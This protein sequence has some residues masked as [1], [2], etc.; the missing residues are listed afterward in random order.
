[1]SHVPGNYTKGVAFWYTTLLPAGNHDYYFEFNNGT[2]RH[3][4]YY[5]GGG[6]NT[7]NYTLW[8]T[9]YFQ[10]PLV[11]PHHVI[12]YQGKVSPSTGYPFTTYNYTVTYYN[13]NGTAPTSAVVYINGQGYNM[14]HV[15][16][17]YANGV[18]FWYAT[19]VSG[20]NNKYYFEFKEGPR[21]DVFPENGGPGNSLSGPSVTMDILSLSKGKVTPTSGYLYTTFNYTVIYWGG[22]PINSGNGNDDDKDGSVD[23]E[24]FNGYDDDGDGFIDEDCSN[25]HSKGTGLA[26]S[27]AY[28]YFDGKAH[29][30][31]HVPGNYSRGITFW[32]STKL[33][34]GNHQYYFYFELG[35]KSKKIPEVWQGNQTN[36]TGPYVAP[37]YTSL[38]NGTVTPKTGDQDTTFTYQVEY[39][40]NYNYPPYW[41]HVFIDGKQCNMTYVSGSNQTGAIYEYKTKLGI[42]SHNYFFNTTTSGESARAPK[43][44]TYSGP[45]V[46]KTGPLLTNGKVSPTSGYLFT[47]FNYTVTYTHTQ[48]RAPSSAKLYIDDQAMTMNKMQGNY[49]L[50]VTYW[51]ST[52]LSAGNHTYRFEFVSGNDTVKLPAQGN[53]T[54][55]TVSSS[56]DQAVWASV[57]PTQGYITTNFKYT[58]GYSTGGSIISF[59]DVKVVIDNVTFNM[60]KKSGQ[61]NTEVWEYTTTLAIGN[62]DYYFNVKVGSTTIKVPS[63]GK[64]TGPKV[65]DK[66][67]WLMSG[68]VTPTAGYANTTMF[69]FTVTYGDLEGKSPTLAQVYVNGSYHNM[70]YVSGSNKTGASYRYGTTLWA[71]NY[72]YHFKFSDGTTTVRLPSTGEYPGPSVTKPG[73][74][75]NYPPELKNGTVSPS[76][77]NVSTIFTYS[78]YYRDKNGDAASV[79]EVVIDGI[80]FNMTGATGLVN[81]WQYFFYRTNLTSTGLHKYY[82]NFR[83]WPMNDIRFRKALWM[84]ADWEQ[85]GDSLGR[86]C[87]AFERRLRDA[88]NCGRDFR[89]GGWPLRR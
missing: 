42:G 17:N 5:S 89:A 32:Y 60:T 62:H 78:V 29:N 54:G 13:M 4:K 68:K 18:T 63:S 81:G 49:S 66:P 39:T 14:S 24:S 2:L 38:T 23:E 59:T 80:A 82:F 9:N 48:D 73:Q 77:G 40:N 52:N 69:N 76:E 34:S 8:L 57:Q 50:G 10:G 79:H 28:V 55:P 1:M 70:Y 27:K 30:M 72:Q 26:P 61:N 19:K 74:P 37:S 58:L 6:G 84:G 64:Y 45:T 88:S 85:A 20:R 41:V 46:I 71:G 83:R 36:Y 25:M 86:C 33:S 15:P 16:G 22:E 43:T 7:S 87:G 12:L 65:I 53:Y 3:P 11:D 31:N 21:S 47:T 51:Y 75:I 35:V 56:L 44:G 67:P